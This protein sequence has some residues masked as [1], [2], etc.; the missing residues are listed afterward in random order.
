MLRLIAY[1]F[2]QPYKWLILIPVGFLLTLV[3]G[4]LA[5][6]FSIVLN[7]KTGSFIGGAIW[8]RTIGLLTPMFVRIE[9]K[10]NIA[11]SKSYIITPNHQS[12]YDVFALYGWIGLDIRWIMKKEIRKIPGVGIGSEK[13]GHIFLDR[14]NRRSALKSLEE[15]K[16]KLSNGSS[17]VIFPEGTRGNGKTLLPFKRGAFKLA[18]DLGLPILPVTIN[19]TNRIL[20]GKSK[21]NIL[22]GKACLHIHKPIDIEGYNEENIKELM[23]RVKTSIES[24]LTP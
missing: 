15:A 2:Y 14:S 12:M 16:Q 21:I 17:V 5:V 8:S 24:K 6:I 23:V 22:P 19:G 13:V 7:Q 10:E 20:H 9:G 4:T 11:K 18:L 1:I 3:F